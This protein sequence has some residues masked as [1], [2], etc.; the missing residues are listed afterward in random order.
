VLE[1]L[2]I[3]RRGAAGRGGAA[4]AFSYLMS[5]ETTEWNLQH[6]HPQGSW[7]QYVNDQQ[8]GERTVVGLAIMALV[9]AVLVTW[10]VLV[11]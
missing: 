2:C 8:F 1:R 3:T 6:T 11:A 5:V 9:S 4:D 10:A 7:W